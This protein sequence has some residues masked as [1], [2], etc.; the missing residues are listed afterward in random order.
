MPQVQ[1]GENILKFFLKEYDEDAG[2]VR[3]VQNKII[4]RDFECGNGISYFT[5]AANLLIG[6]KTVNF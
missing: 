1:M 2:W 3:L 6:R 5:N 4:S